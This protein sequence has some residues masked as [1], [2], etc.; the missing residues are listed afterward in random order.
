MGGGVIHSSR[1]L[2]YYYV[3]Y[4]TTYSEASTSFFV[5]YLFSHS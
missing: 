1:T 4:P 5:M 3:P 2:P